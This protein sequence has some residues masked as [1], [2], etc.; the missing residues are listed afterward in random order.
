VGGI[1]LGDE[2]AA[3]AHD[4]CS[5]SVSLGCPPHR[6]PHRPHAPRGDAAPGAPAPWDGRRWSVWRARLDAERRDDERDVTGERWTVAK[7]RL[8]FREEQ[9]H[10]PHA[11]RGNAA[12]GAPAPW[13]G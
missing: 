9:P 8:D 7:E 13:D 3:A 1:G 5:D 6:S 10:R 4:S 2:V 12:P 11:L